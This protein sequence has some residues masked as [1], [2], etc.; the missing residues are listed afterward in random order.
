MAG[1]PRE[2]VPTAVFGPLLVRAMSEGFDLEFEGGR[3]EALAER[4][5]CPADTIYRI[6]IRRSESCDFDLADRLLCALNVPHWWWEPPLKEVYDSIVLLERCRLDGCNRYFRPGRVKEGATRKRYCSKK[7]A[8][9]DFERRNGLPGVVQRDGWCR[10]GLHEM[11][12]SNVQI[13]TNGGR[14]CRACR[15]ASYRASYAKKKKGGET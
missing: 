7:H 2:G 1:T 13:K 8:A 12:G 10:K 4:V 14:Q 15:L 6:S 9:A 5:Q 11:K 3:I